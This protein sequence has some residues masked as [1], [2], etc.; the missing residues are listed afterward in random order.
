M[1]LLSKIVEVRKTGYGSS[2]QLATRALQVA[3]YNIDRIRLEW[4]K[5]WAVIGEH[6]KSAGC[7]ENEVRERGMKDGELK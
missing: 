3:F 4:T 6:L 1:F 5:I 2:G 7:N